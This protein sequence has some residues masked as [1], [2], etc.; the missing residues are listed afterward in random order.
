[1][2]D[3]NA[4]SLYTDRAG[5]IWVGTYQKGLQRVDPATGAFSAPILFGK[6]NESQIRVITQLADGAMLIGTTGGG[7]FELDPRSGTKRPFVVGKAGLSGSASRPN[8][9][10][11]GS[12]R[13]TGSIAS[14]AARASSTT[15]PSRTAFPA[16]R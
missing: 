2:A 1:M 10:P 9:A 11:S 13:R 16:A 7:M 14:I 4:F 6:K 8:P 15:T 3:D 12:A 5:Q